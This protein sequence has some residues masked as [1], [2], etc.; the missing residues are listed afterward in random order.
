MR[1]GLGGHARLA[2]SRWSVGRG[3]LHEGLCQLV[4]KEWYTVNPQEVDG[5]LGDPY[6]LGV[7]AAH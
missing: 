4:T 1:G 6:V 2:P 5:T 3:A 7:N